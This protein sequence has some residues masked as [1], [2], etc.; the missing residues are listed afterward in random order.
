MQAVRNAGSRSTVIVTVGLIA[1]GVQVGSGTGNPFMIRVW[2]PFGGSV[3][4]RSG[5]E[6]RL[7]ML[8]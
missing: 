2:Q 1:P 5:L 6:A 3:T 8:N 7:S 4:S